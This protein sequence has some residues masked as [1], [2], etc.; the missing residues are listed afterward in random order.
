[1]RVPETSSLFSTM[2][3]VKY[4]NRNQTADETLDSSVLTCYY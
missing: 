4:K 1:M 2:K 3:Q